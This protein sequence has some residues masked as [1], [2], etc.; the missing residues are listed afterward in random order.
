MGSGYWTEFWIFFDGSGV[1]HEINEYRGNWK[2]LS[3]FVFFVL[4]R[5]LVSCGLGRIR[6]RNAVLYYVNL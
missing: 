2:G 3:C 5:L 6:Y 4:M 1:W